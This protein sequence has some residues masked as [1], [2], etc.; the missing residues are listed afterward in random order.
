M[1][2]ANI[3]AKNVAIMKDPSIAIVFSFLKNEKIE[4]VNPKGIMTITLGQPHINIKI[5]NNSGPNLLN[6]PL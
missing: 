6:P 4:N 3:S 5:N 1:I 2:L